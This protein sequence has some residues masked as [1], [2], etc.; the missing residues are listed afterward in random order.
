MYLIM[1]IINIMISILWTCP[2]MTYCQVQSK[3]KQ[4]KDCRLVNGNQ[5]DFIWFCSMFQGE[6]S[7]LLYHH[8][9][10]I[11]SDTFWRSKLFFFLLWKSH[12]YHL[13]TLDISPYYQWQNSTEC[14]SATS[15]YT[16]SYTDLLLVIQ[17]DRKSIMLTYLFCWCFL[18]SRLRNKLLFLLLILLVVMVVH[19]LTID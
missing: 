5:S 3:T 9:C 10:T 16:E 7:G 19:M 6:L 2:N 13:Y 17:F 14:I 15:V 1:N 12:F 18:G 4:F 8:L 11:K